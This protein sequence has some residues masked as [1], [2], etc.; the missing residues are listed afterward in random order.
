MAS[1]K[2]NLNPVPNPNA[3]HAIVDL[4]YRMGRLEDSVALNRVESAQRDTQIALVKADIGTIKAGQDKI[5]SGLNRI[6]WTVG[7]GIAGAATTFVMSGGL[8]I[9]QQ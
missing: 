9:L 4:H 8:I 7:L 1:I 3:E 6:L 5:Y 2:P